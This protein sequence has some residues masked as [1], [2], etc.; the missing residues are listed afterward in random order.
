MSEM[1]KR[2]NDFLGME[3]GKLPPQAVDLEIAILGACLLDGKAIDLLSTI[4]QPEHFYKDAHVKMFKAIVE[5]NEAGTSID[6]LTVT[7][8]LQKMGELEIVGG[9]LAI[10]KLTDR[11][12]SS[13]N[14]IEHAHI[15]KQ[16]WM[17]REMIRLGRDMANEAYEESDPFS[18]VEKYGKKIAIMS[19]DHSKTEFVRI[20]NI[21]PSAFKHI[22]SVNSSTQNVS[23]LPS[24]IPSVDK[25]LFGLL[26][27]DLMYIGARP[28]MGKTAFIL[29]MA[30]LQASNGI[31]VAIFSMEMKSELLVFRLISMLTGID[32]TRIMKQKMS[33]EE[34]EAFHRA[35]GYIESLPI[36]IDDTPALSAYEFHV[37]A[38]RMVETNG[39]KIFYLDYVQLMTLGTKKSREMVDSKANELTEVSRTLKKT[40]ME[41]DVPVVGLAQLSREVEKRSGWSKR[42]IMS[43]LK[44][45]GSLEQDGDVVGFL[46]RPEYYDLKGDNG[47]D[48]KGYAE[49]IIGKNRN[50]AIGIAKTKF[51]AE[52]AYFSDE[53]YEAKFP[54]KP[55]DRIDFDQADTLHT[56]TEDK[57]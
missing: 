30:L 5:M 20:K 55:A 56:T 14:I 48:F 42:P 2:Q 25:L 16:Q 6:I 39:I 46:F 4:L 17:S 15:V 26:G 24:F 3:M 52:Q 31:P 32:V 43:D 37:K 12:A 36:W 11:I 1:K 40:A 51:H 57:F 50:G 7:H 21:L 54:V 10:S 35:S 49:L 41:C 53:E 13:G 44:D 45:S 27:G 33:S 23:G 28:S 22:E 38:K 47:Y 29:T 34:F 9:P 8:Y 19:S 18:L